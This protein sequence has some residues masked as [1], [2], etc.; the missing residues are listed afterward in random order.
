MQGKGCA[1][2]GRRRKEKGEAWKC[3]QEKR[4]AG[5]YAQVVRVSGIRDCK[6]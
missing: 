5:M 6:E 1:E 4:R 2:R 3:R